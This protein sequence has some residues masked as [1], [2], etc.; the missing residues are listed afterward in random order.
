MLLTFLLTLFYDEEKQFSVM[1]VLFCQSCT[2]QLLYYKLMCL[3]KIWRG[4]GQLK[5]ILVNSHPSDW[6]GDN[7]EFGT[8]FLVVAL[9]LVSNGHFGCYY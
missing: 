8:E 4:G 6:S 2:T 3:S 7:P 5:T 1:Q 9:L